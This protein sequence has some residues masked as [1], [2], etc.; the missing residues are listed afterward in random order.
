MTKQQ[1]I[2][3]FIKRLDE[4]GKYPSQDITGYRAISILEEILPN[5]GEK[6]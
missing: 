4:L 3:A 1:I 5:N 2:D 6:E